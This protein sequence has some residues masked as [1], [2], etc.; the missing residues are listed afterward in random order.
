MN[1]RERTLT[2]RAR[3]IH[4]RTRASCWWERTPAGSE[5]ARFDDRIPRTSSTR[6]DRAGVPSPARS[7]T[8]TSRTP[9]SPASDEDSRGPALK[10][11][12]NDM[13]GALAFGRRRLRDV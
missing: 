7:G 13:G 5:S 11:L 10:S 12:G 9:P 8:L 4:C 6:M 3:L 2:A 1:A